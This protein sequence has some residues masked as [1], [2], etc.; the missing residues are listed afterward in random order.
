MI[1]LHIS[2]STNI[3]NST[4][5]DGINDPRTWILAELEKV[6]WSVM[7][8]DGRSE[9][10]MW[11]CESVSSLCSISATEQREVF[12]ELLRVKSV[13]RSVAGRIWGMVFEKEPRAAGAV[14]GRNG[15]LLEKF[16]EG[17]PRRILQWFD[18]FSLAGDSQHGK[19]AKA[20]SQFAFVNRDICWEEL[21]WKGRHGQSPAVV[22][23]KPHYFLDLDVQRTV[24]NIIDNVPEFWSSEEFADSVKDG[25]ILSIDT[26]FFVDFFVDLMYEDN[27]EEVWKVIDKFLTEQSFSYLCRHLLIILDETTL[28]FFLEKIHDILRKKKELSLN[29][30]SYWLEILFSKCSDRAAIDQLL[31]LN[32]IH[33]K[34]RQLLR[35]LHA[36]EAAEEKERVKDLVL[37]YSSISG[38]SNSQVL[39]PLKSP[40]MK[41]NEILKWVGLLAWILLYQ[42][43]EECHTPQSWESLFLSNGIGF[44]EFGEYNILQQ[45]IDSENSGSDLDDV[46]A[47]R[48]NHK[49]K[50][51]SKKKRNRS[52]ARILHDDLDDSINRLKM[53]N[54]AGTWLLSTDGYSSSWCS[55]DL[56]EYLSKHCLSTWIKQLLV[57]MED[58]S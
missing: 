58:N 32:A 26:K 48:A 36:D 18:T 56:P 6:I 33:T 23:T 2:K 45:D 7:I 37:Q 50:R 14:L 49:R 29:S 34:G 57:E 19:G 39:I 27:M 30:P 8:T 42:M 5:S 55:V 16:F 40:K 38:P 47:T 25:E 17:H 52:S 9:A 44:R 31:L 24:E 1:D 35:L 51:K 12:S 43:S 46:S 15:I 4:D 20:L 28:C 13:R 41:I 22:A 53:Q 54:S 3:H 10:R 21:E 11:L